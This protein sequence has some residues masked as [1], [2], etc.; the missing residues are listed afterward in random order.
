MVVAAIIG[1]GSGRPIKEAG[2][3]MTPRSG[4]GQAVRMD[5]AAWLEGLGFDSTR[6]RSAPTTSTASADDAHRGRPARDGCR[7]D[8][9]PQ[10]APGSHRSSGRRAAGRPK[11]S[12]LVPIRS[13][14]SGVSASRAAPAHRHVRGSGGFDGAGQRLELEEMREVVRAY[15]NAR[16]RRDGALRGPRGANHG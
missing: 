14:R 15:Q 7:V 2:Q 13:R 4:I 1:I 16:D 5:I 11:P 6:K 10:E 8:R 3:V 9:P 12:L